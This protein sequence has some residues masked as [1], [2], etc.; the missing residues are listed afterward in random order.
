V[1]Q[2]VDESPKKGRKKKAEEEETVWKW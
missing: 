1:K 2:E